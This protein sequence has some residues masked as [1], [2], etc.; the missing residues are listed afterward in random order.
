MRVGDCLKVG[1]IAGRPAARQVP[2]GSVDSNF[3]VVATPAGDQKCPGDVD[4]SYSQRGAFSDSVSTLCLDIDWVVGG[5]MSVDPGH[6]T[7]PVRV[8]C[9]D[10]AAPHRQRATQ[11]LRGVAAVDQCASGQGYAYPERRYTVCVENMA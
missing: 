11:I 1:G 5:C 4:S 3:K 10:T 6:T 8:A 7:D 2:C 9:T